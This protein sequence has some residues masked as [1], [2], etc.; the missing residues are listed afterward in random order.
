[1]FAVVEFNYL[2]I[3]IF[4]DKHV[5]FVVLY[6]TFNSIYICNFCVFNTMR[7][8]DFKDL[9]NYKVYYQLFRHF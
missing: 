4:I 6:L 5:L 2:I 7:Y 9:Y 8:S 3:I 1:M